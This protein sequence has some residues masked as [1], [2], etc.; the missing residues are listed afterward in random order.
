MKILVTCLLLSATSALADH[1]TP[2]PPP[3]GQVCL[4]SCCTDDVDHVYGN[5]LVSWS[6]LTEWETRDCSDPTGDCIPGGHERCY[7]LG[8]SED[9]I[10][11]EEI[12]E[13]CEY[14]TITWNDDTQSLIWIY[15]PPSTIFFPYRLD[16]PYFPTESGE[17]F[18]KVK[19]CLGD[20]Q[21]PDRECSA[22]TE[23]Q[24]ELLGVPYTCMNNAL[25]YRCESSC[26]SG[27]PDRI[28]QIPE[29]D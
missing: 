3:A 14:A 4:F 26:Y 18:Y 21:D 2:C 10:N 20:M 12:W 24:V 7:V 8:F 23:Q 22:W 29:C 28:P 13:N 11:W 16:P 1:L 9:A 6:Q 25:E 19:T 17:Y 5:E 27:A 15:R